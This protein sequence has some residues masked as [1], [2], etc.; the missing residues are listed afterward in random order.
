MMAF[1]E[2]RQPSGVVRRDGKEDFTRRRWRERVR[3]AV[4]KAQKPF[5]K[6]AGNMGYRDYEVNA[7]QHARLHRRAARRGPWEMDGSVQIAHPPVGKSPTP[8]EPTG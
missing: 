2:T 6:R 4:H 5:P 1:E 3:H 7:R 8:S